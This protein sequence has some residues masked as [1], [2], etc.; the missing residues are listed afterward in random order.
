MAAPK[1]TAER[2]RELLHYD[3]DT[4]IFTNRIRR[5]NNPAGSI[6]GARQRGRYINIELD[7]RQYSGHRLAWLYVYGEWPTHNIDH[8]NGDGRD[9]RFCNLRDVAQA[10]NLQNRRGYGETGVKNVYLKH[11]GAGG[12]WTYYEV[13]LN[14]NGKT[15][16]SKLFKTLAEAEAAAIEARA[17]YHT[18][19][20]S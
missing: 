7:D 10:L 11:K 5:G 12:R 4:G 3:P 15:V 13:A 17:K 1:L 2:V 14:V 16:Y 9:N 18:H 20:R 6:V 19:T 8:I